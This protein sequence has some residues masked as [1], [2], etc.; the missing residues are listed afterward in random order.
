MNGR[1]PCGWDRGR[2]GESGHVD[3]PRPD[4]DQMHPEGLLADDLGGGEQ[5]AESKI[6]LAAALTKRNGAIVVA[7]EGHVDGS[8]S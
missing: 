8:S 6:R 3:W 5:L 4:L 7:A 1:P 2:T